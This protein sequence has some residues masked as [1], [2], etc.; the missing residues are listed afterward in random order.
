[1]CAGQHVEGGANGP[2]EA[3]HVEQAARARPTRYEKHS[4]RCS[5]GGRALMGLRQ[6]SRRRGAVAGSA[7][8][9]IAST[10]RLQSSVLEMPGAGG[11]KGHTI[12]VA[13]VDGILRVCR[14]ADTT[15]V[16]NGKQARWTFKLERGFPGQTIRKSEQGVV[17]KNK[18][19]KLD[20]LDLAWQAHREAKAFT[21][22]GI[23]I[24]RFWHGKPTERQAC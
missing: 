24:T 1:M 5:A 6:R 11:H 4:M 20:N 8:S 19:T 15:L 22:F 7:V 17:Q 16:S 18:V 9:H 13:A 12:L 3:Q 2:F 23:N 10:K 14:K 21:P